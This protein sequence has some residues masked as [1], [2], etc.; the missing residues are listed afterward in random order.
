M[1]GIY[2]GKKKRKLKKKKKEKGGG[3]E[4]GG[5]GTG[6]SS[7]G[8]PSVSILSS[9]SLPDFSSSSPSGCPSSFRSSSSFS[10]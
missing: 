4:K 2:G 5:E 10:K 3:G 8:S 9:P 1:E 6:D 7:N